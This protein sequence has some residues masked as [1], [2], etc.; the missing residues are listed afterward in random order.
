MTLTTTLVL[1]AATAFAEHRKMDMGMTDMFTKCDTN[2]DGS[3]SKEEFLA[4]KTKMFTKH[5]LNND[6]KISKDEN[7]KMVEDMR[8]MRSEN[9]AMNMK[10]K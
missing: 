6:G 9:H 8:Q 10:T 4:E 5:D 7:E 3:L 1:L 2:G